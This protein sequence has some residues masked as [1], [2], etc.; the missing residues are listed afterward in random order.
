VSG[1]PGARPLSSAMKSLA[2][3]LLCF[4]TVLA[5]GLGAGENYRLFGHRG[6][7][8]EDKFPDNSAAA[9]HGAVARGYWGLEIDIRE[10]QDGV[11]VMQHD[12]DLAQNFGDPR[13][14]FESSWSDLQP[15]RTKLAH[16]PL[17]RFE[18]VVQAAHAAGLRLMLDSKDP[19]TAGFP[20]K[21]EAILKKYDMVERCYIIGTGDAMSH[22]TGK[23]LVG[24]KFRGLK[25]IIEADPTAKDRFF[26][27][28]EGRVL[29]EEMVQ[30]A[31]ARGVRVVPSINVYHYY[32]PA[33]MTG[34]SPAELK[35]IILAAARKHVEAFKALGVTEFQIDSEFDG[36]F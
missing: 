24:K 2:A 15:L 18:D 33:T 35:P 19:H 10:T 14:I 31:Q 12:P 23:A 16:Q 36:W 1:L 25:A 4:T 28:E 29:T 17:W 26:L 13:K 20:A 8:V 22:F 3:G 21:V 30:W 11:L 32:D 27:F 7:V 6:G 34:K 9:L 5:S